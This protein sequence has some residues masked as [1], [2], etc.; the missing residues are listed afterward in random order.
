MTDIWG[1]DVYTYNQ[2]SNHYPSFIQPFYFDPV[3]PAIRSSLVGAA[4]YQNSTSVMESYSKYSSYGN[5]L[6]TKQRYDSVGVQW[7]TASATYDP[8]GN[9]LTSTDPRGN[10]VYNV[11]SSA[12]QN[13][14]LT[15]QTKRDEQTQI[16]SRF[17]YNFT[18]GVRLWTFDPRSYN[19]TYR[20]DIL[21]RL[22]TVTYP[23]S[24]G[25]VSYSYVDSGNY[26]DMTNS[27]GW[28]T[29]QIYDRLGRQSV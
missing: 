5:V 12:Y 9:V 7:I 24:L 4:G 28:K 23:N 10:T 13:A 18:N 1:G 20:Y 14:Y 15:N 21:G 6:Q 3:N 26:V 17:G 19:T 27:N 11:Y 2:P 29:R 8:Y 16:T 22:K 25:S